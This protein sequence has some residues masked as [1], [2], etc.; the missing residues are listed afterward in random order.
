MGYTTEF[1]GGFNCTPQL[2]E[3]HANYLRQFAATRRMQRDPRKA[4]KLDD[5]LRQ[6]VGL[7]IGKDGCYFVGGREFGGQ[8]DDGSI[9]D[10]N[11]PP[12][13]QPG[14]WCQWTPSRYTSSIEWDGGEKFYFY[15]EW[16]EYLIE[17]FLK[18]WGY[19]LNGE[20]SYAGEDENDRGII[21][22]KDNVVEVVQDEITNPGP[23]W[24]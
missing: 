4:E 15:E 3:E 11:S 7:P 8:G 2:S 24:D 16:L 21:Y 17:H 5:P 10:F 9:L 22:S 23:S 19:K 12:A 1:S 18:P 14:L 6:A 13:D 20:V